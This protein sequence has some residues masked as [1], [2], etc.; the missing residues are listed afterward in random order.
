MPQTNL[1]VEPVYLQEL[2]VPISL[3]EVGAWVTKL[4]VRYHTEPSWRR[5]FLEKR[6]ITKD[7]QDELIPLSILCKKMATNRPNSYLQYF[8]G[9]GQSFDAKILS[10][11]GVVQ[12]VLEVTLACDGLQERMATE[13]LIAHGYA[14]LWSTIQ[15]T[16]GNRRNRIIPLPELVSLDS[17]AIVEE[18]ISQVSNAVARKSDS[19]KYENVNLVVAFEDFRLLSKAHH[20]LAIQEF[21][22]I[23]SRFQVVYFVGLNKQVFLRHGSGA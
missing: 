2:C 9:S 21:K 5:Y 14:P 12:E 13:A 18:C 11:S 17:D 1:I 23:K 16:T 10:S 6:G 3:P 22:G 8:Q 19:G 7:I 4:C 20:E 15:D